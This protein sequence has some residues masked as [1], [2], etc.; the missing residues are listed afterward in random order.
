MSPLFR[1]DELLHH[2]AFLRAVASRLV[3]A[4]DV[5]DL[6][7]STWL[8]TAE[9]GPAR[10]GRIRAWL[11]TVARNLGG[12]MRRGTE[13]RRRRET[14]AGAVQATALGAPTPAEFAEREQLRRAVADAI[15]AL[16]DASRDA[17]L[18]RWYEGLSSR[19]AAAR[20]GVPVETLRTRLK[21]AHAKLRTTLDA[22]YGRRATW[23]ALAGP[24]AVDA[25]ASIGKTV[26]GALMT[27]T[28]TK[29]AA[30]LGVIC[31]ALLGVIVAVFGPW[32]GSDGPPPVRGDGG[33]P[34][35]IA[36]PASSRPTT[37]DASSLVA[38]ASRRIASRP[39]VE[40]KD[41]EE[42]AVA[43]VAPS[44]LRLEVH[45][46][47][48]SPA[49]GI[50]VSAR[51]EGLPE[52]AG[53]LES[54]DGLGLWTSLAA[55]GYWLLRLD[56]TVGFR[57]VFVKPLETTVCTWLLEPGPTLEGET[58]DGRGRPVAGA[59]IV[60]ASG[61]NALFI[62]AKSDA[63]GRFRVRDVAPDLSVSARGAGFAPSEGAL[64]GGG[65]GTTVWR[66][67][68]LNTGGAAVE[69]R[70]VDAAGAAIVGATVEAT[71][72]TPDG[73][74]VDFQRG[75]AA[76][77]GATDAEGRF[78]LESL[79]DGQIRITTH[80]SGFAVSTLDTELPPEGTERVSILLRRGARLTG[81]AKGFEGKDT[82]IHVRGISRATLVGRVAEDGS[83]TVEDV[84]P[85]S[86]K[87]LWTDGGQ[88]LATAE[89]EFE[90]G[91]I[92]R[93]EPTVTTEATI[94]G[95]VVDAAGLPL[96]GLQVS[97]HRRFGKTFVMRAVGRTDPEGR[98]V[99]ATK[100]R[101][102]L[103]LI[104]KHA[105]TGRV[106]AS[107]DDVLPGS[108]E[109]TIVVAAELLPTAHVIGRLFRPDGAPATSGFLMIGLDVDGDQDGS[110]F[111]ERPAADGGFRLGPYPAGRIRL[112]FEAGDDRAPFPL[113]DR[114]VSAG[115]TWDLGDIRLPDPVLVTVKVLNAD[116]SPDR[117][118]DV[119]LCLPDG[120]V[121]G[122]GGRTNARG[123]LRLAI[124][125]TACMLVAYG[126]YRRAPTWLELKAGFATNAAAPTV[127]L[128]RTAPAPLKIHSTG[129]G[130]IRIRLPSGIQ[131]AVLVLEK[132][133][134][135]IPLPLGD[136][137][138]ELRSSGATT[139]KITRYV[140]APNAAP[141]VLKR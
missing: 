4:D 112:V 44:G 109:M 71:A 138:F 28:Q 57:R 99:V 59:E 10:S 50:G 39:F 96:P 136:Y 137:D 139:G 107:A 123:E 8:A 17:V 20:L 90:A 5:D 47:D 48:G 51:P 113:G 92:T 66:V 124:P 93:W 87:A 80:A 122:R 81:R 37:D 2:D 56:R 40:P 69:G 25:V 128:R 73:A 133:A 94:K 19:E 129:G 27:T 141:L 100:D 30:T 98:F 64:V 84:P 63:S 34:L 132:D 72:M 101:D 43:A 54:T 117:D 3:A 116:D 77:R 79:P 110:L 6:V 46:S 26:F 67:L 36:P 135:S 31:A 60:L 111:A 16:D 42:P 38:A 108:P 140:V 32:R 130:V 131:L 15:L 68:V 86:A 21:R 134:A 103:R 41:Q 119:I 58:V 127:T 91:G 125:P 82:W 61:P 29:F 18:L 89:L 45:Y 52:I 55:P 97:V 115:E 22:R 49:A 7:Q 85:G 120:S 75:T 24:G 13:R 74:V 78:R 104:V 33:D 1:T 83:F 114:V 53:R 76:V 118:A 23:A 95:R 35:A 12:K 14:A 11:A 70:V 65:A 105:E 121:L 102:P 126:D 9:Q 88:V 106:L 62:A